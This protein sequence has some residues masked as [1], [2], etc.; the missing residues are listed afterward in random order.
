MEC[1]LYHLLLWL[2]KQRKLSSIKYT[3]PYQIVSVSMVR[4]W[5]LTE[6]SKY[7]KK[8]LILQNHSVRHLTFP[9]GQEMTRGSTIKQSPICPAWPSNDMKGSQAGMSIL[10][11]AIFVRGRVKGTSSK[12]RLP[13]CQ[14]SSTLVVCP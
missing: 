12:V 8:I 14:C 9:C 10:F 2:P 11:L 1:Q 4:D 7:V 13:G 5:T 3:K 6:A